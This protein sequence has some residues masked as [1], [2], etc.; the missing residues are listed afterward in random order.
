MSTVIEQL[1]QRMLR[2]VPAF[3]AGDTVRVHF[4]VIEGQRH[5][6]PLCEFC[7]AVCYP[8]S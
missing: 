2:D 3:K 5:R 8:M 4:K 6:K 1:E 7:M